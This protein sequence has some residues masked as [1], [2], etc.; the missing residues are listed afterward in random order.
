MPQTAPLCRALILATAAAIALAARAQAQDASE[1]AR[2]FAANCTTC[3]GADAK[4]ARGPSLVSGAWKHGSSAPEI[5]R[6]I[7]DGIP[8]TEMPAFPLSGDEPQAIAE[9]LL[10]LNR[11]PDDRVTGDAN[12]GRQIFFGVG[13]CS[14][15]HSIQGSGGG[16]GPDL[17]GIGAQ[18]SARDLTRAIA[19]P[20]D[21][22]R[23]GNKAAEVQTADGKRIR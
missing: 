13:G 7:H 12:A 8:G 21:N 6:N 22:P 1:A 2:L 15:C 17:T 9:W 11:G 18:R 5:A 20:G 3:H 14:G 10:S 16:F 23:G 4:G 19:N